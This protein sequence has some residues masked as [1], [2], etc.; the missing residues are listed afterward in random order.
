[1]PRPEIEKVVLTARLQSPERSRS[2]A[3]GETDGKEASKTALKI[4]IE[5]MARIMNIVL[6]SPE[7]TTRLLVDTIS[8]RNSPGI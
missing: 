2:V 7:A 3:A 6:S 4:V 8:G 5:E 1:L